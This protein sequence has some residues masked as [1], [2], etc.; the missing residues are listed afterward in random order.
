MLQGY[1]A[2]QGDAWQYTLKALAEYYENASQSGSLGPREVPGA[3]LLTL[4]VEA[5]PDD[6]RRR[7]GPYLDAAALL[8][9][10]TAELHLALAS[11]PEDPE[12]APQLFTATDRQAFANSAIQLLT[13]NF[14]LLRRLKNELPDH[15]QDDA[16]QGPPT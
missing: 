12:F 8:G 10:R 3:P 6:A 15:A 7:I 11:V 13:A 14:A 16:G 9:R 1:V 4:S 2:N 5:I